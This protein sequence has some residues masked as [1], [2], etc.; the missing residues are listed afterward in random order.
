MASCD[1]SNTNTLV[2]LKASLAEMSIDLANTER[3]LTNPML[4]YNLSEKLGT[5]K[6]TLTQKIEEVQTNEFL[7]SK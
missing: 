4:G 5:K 1:S 3:R 7:K 6:R 2:G